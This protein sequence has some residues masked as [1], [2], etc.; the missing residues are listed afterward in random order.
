MVLAK[1]TQFGQ[2]YLGNAPEVLDAV[3]VTVTGSKF[4]VAVVDAVVLL[5]A[6][7]NQAV[8]TVPAVIS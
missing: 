4:V 6:P 1:P 2:P 8:I 3:D 5:V 7:V